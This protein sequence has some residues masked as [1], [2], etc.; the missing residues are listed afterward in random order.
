MVPGMLRQDW[1]T[2][3]SNPCHPIRGRPGSCFPLL[4]LPLSVY[5]GASCSVYL[6]YIFVGFVALLSSVVVVPL[7]GCCLPS[8]FV[9][10]LETVPCYYLSVSV[11]F[12]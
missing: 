5:V 6:L 7:F 3:A 11:D 9:E 8:T 2:V 4:F 12:C 10:S 1:E